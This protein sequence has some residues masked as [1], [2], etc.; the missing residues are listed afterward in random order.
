[1]EI[2][3]DLFS[4]DKFIRRH[5]I[6]AVLLTVGLFLLATLMVL[7]F[8]QPVLIKSIFTQSH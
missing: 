8:V 2:L 7:Y 5:A 3:F 6:I 4:K 1:M